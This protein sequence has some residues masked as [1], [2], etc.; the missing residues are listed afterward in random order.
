MFYR[1]PFFCFE[2]GKSG[3]SF[4]YHVSTFQTKNKPASTCSDCGNLCFVTANEKQ[5]PRG[6]EK[7][8]MKGFSGMEQHQFESKVL[9]KQANFYRNKRS[10]GSM[11]FKAHGGRV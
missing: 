11:T 4:Q 7:V 9:S 3:K 2:S 8:N 6:V 5:F 1:K 10:R